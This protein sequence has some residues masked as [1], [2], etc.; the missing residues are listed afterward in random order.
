M[1]GDKNKNAICALPLSLLALIITFQH[2]YLN[3][4]LVHG[5]AKRNGRFYCRDEPLN[6]PPSFLSGLSLVLGVL[7]RS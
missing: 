6:D 5:N 3:N 4:P 1:T 7:G 2:N